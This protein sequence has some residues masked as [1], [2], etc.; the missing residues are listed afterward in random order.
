MAVVVA[1]YGVL[2]LFQEDHEGIGNE[3]EAP[4]RGIDLD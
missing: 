4:G 1:V 3:R 2:E